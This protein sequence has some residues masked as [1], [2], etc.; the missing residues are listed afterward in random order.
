MSTPSINRG[1]PTLMKLSHSL[2]KAFGLQTTNA[3][4]LLFFLCPLHVNCVYCKFS[5]LRRL[6]WFPI[7]SATQLCRDRCLLH[8]CCLI[9]CLFVCQWPFE[10]HLF[11]KVFSV[12]G[13]GTFWKEYSWQEKE[14]N[15]ILLNHQVSQKK[16]QPSSCK[17]LRMD[18]PHRDLLL[19]RYSLPQPGQPSGAI[20]LWSWPTLSENPCSWAILFYHLPLLLSSPIQPDPTL[21]GM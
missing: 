3:Y 8:S 15:F 9:V 2:E 1:F 19:H 11:M 21:T 18:R 6:S 14:T 17:K 16:L 13:R 20:F 4:L 12:L 5:L 7:I 10:F